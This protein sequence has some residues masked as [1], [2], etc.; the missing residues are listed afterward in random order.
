MRAAHAQICCSYVLV[1]RPIN[2]TNSFV[3]TNR[4]ILSAGYFMAKGLRKSRFAGRISRVYISLTS[5]LEQIY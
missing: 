2:D 1:R 5:F 4:E 3:T